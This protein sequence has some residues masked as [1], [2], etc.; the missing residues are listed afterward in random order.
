MI[1]TI[2]KDFTNGLKAI[3]NIYVSYFN[4]H[5]GNILK[6]TQISFRIFNIT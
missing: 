6:S 5:K 4:I 1:K 3:E 2:Q